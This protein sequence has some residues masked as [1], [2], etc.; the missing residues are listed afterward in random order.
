MRLKY[1]IFLTLLCASAVLIAT[2]FAI[3]NWS[4]SRGFLEYV[5][6]NEIDRLNPIVERLEYNYEQAGNWDWVVKEDL[7]ALSPKR[8]RTPRQRGPG[9][10]RRSPPLVLADAQKKALVGKI[11]RR[12]TMQWIELKRD[13]QLVGHLGFPKNIRVDRRFDQLFAQKQT[14]SFAWTALAM[15]VLSALLSIPLASRIVR[16]ILGVNKA[17]SEISG[18]N[19]A[20][21]IDAKRRDE[22]GDLANNINTLGKTLEQN[23]HARQRWIAEISHE[24]RTPLAVLRGEVE[25]VQDGVRKMDKA[26]V[27]SLHGEVLS[28]GRLIDDL[29]TLSMSDVGALSYEMKA[30]NASQF[31]TEFVRANKKKLDE[32]GITLVLSELDVSAPIQ[33]D[34][35]RLEQL[36]TNLL[37][38]TCRYTDAGGTLQV[39]L[40]SENIEN[41][42]YLTIHWQDSSPGV[43]ASAIPQLFDPLFR[44][45]GSR[46]RE[47][48]GSGLGL[49]IAKRIV[50][51]HDGFIDA[52]ESKLGGLHIRISLPMST[53]RT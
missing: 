10:P 30:I 3:S 48:G 31:V 23:Q 20:H 38:N 5:N 53:K 6:Q 33:G 47:L 11:S 21:R 12:A 24:L 29:H 8:N 25:A 4:F 50:D 14:K 45:D 1:Q 7:Q 40:E 43:E 42:H 18:G 13:E 22:L 35:Q 34:E 9:E 15:I 41:A 52:S 19:Y 39:T 37:Q 17:V 49:A 16:P 28:L 26:A 44:T 32:Q 36:F 51:A 27:D 2:M 46:N